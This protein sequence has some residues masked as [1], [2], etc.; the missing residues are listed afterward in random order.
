MLAQLRDLTGNPSDAGEI[1][2]SIAALEMR[3][4]KFQQAAMSYLTASQVTSDPTVEQQ[5]L[6]QAA[7]ALSLGRMNE[8]AREIYHQVL[9]KP[10]QQSER[11]QIVRELERLG[12]PP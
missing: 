4:L 2:L 7:R 6:L 9:A 5:A 8:Q 10:L 11:R 12:I 1:Q 3:Q